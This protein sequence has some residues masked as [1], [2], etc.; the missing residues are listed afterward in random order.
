MIIYNMDEKWLW[1]IAI[2]VVI[3][4]FAI[5]FFIFNRGKK[6]RPV[7]YLSLFLIGIIWLFFGIITENIALIVL[8]LIFLIVGLVNRKLW[9][10]NT[11]TWKSLSKK[12]KQVRI[13]LII[14]VILFIVSGFLFF[15]F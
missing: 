9:K 12:E 5:I 10:K 7:D 14:I 11:I 1:M 2:L 6:K 4:I 3:V 15:Y 8:G 13:V